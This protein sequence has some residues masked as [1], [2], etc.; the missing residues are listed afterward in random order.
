MDM[1]MLR[2]AVRVLR[3]RLRKGQASRKDCR[4]YHLAVT[5]YAGNVAEA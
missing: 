5:R 1:S 4:L 2:A 3:E